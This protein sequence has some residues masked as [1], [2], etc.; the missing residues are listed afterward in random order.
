MKRIVS[1]IIVCAML[2]SVLPLSY[3]ESSVN[4]NVVVYDFEDKFQV[5]DPPIRYDSLTYATNNNLWQYAANSKGHDD[6]TSSTGGIR[7]YKKTGEIALVAQNPD[8]TDNKDED[9]AY[10]IAFEI[11]VPKDG[12]YALSVNATPANYGTKTYVDVYF[13]NV[14]SVTK[15]EDGIIPDNKLTSKKFKSDTENETL[16]LGKKELKKGKHYFVFSPG[17]SRSNSS[18]A[19]NGTYVYLNK[20]T[21][22]ADIE[23]E[24]A[25]VSLEKSQLY[26]GEFTKAIASATDNFG[27]DVLLDN[28][29]VEF[30]SSDESVAVVSSA[31]DIYAVNSGTTD[32]TV[33]VSTDKN[34]V[35]SAPQTITVKSRGEAASLPDELSFDF[36]Q[37]FISEGESAAVKI[38]DASGNY[39]GDGIKYTYDIYDDS[40]VTE[41][42]GKFTAKKIGKTKVDVLAELGGEKREFSFDVIVVGENL[43][44]RHG[45]DH[46]QFENSMYLRD[47]SVPGVSTKNTLWYVTKNEVRDNFVY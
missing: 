19:L 6:I 26:P 7:A 24:S 46:G 33:T 12:N 39:P 22:T 43:L 29:N 20:L 14:N 8:K 40:V 38:T 16:S 34:S 25:S 42:D 32:I 9:K 35:T 45:V 17:T 10:W 36:P 44:V 21:L 27:G 31:G 47:G 4:G 5:K 2:L 30:Q 3:A 41:E 18:G 15:L 37:G 28:V 1:M 13:F 11:D 23:L